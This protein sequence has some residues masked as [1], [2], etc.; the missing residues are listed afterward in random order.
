VTKNIIIFL[1]VGIHLGGV[2]AYANHS[3]AAELPDSRHLFAAPSAPNAP[4]RP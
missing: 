3:F 1:I 2:T 4:D